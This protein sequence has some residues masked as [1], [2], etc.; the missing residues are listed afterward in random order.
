MSDIVVE[1]EQGPGRLVVAD[2]ESPRAVLL[3]GHGAGG[4]V[5]AFDLGALAQ[6][7]PGRGITV[8]R[9]SQP[10]R[11]AG[12][13]VAVRP[14]KLDEAWA[15]AVA[16]VAERWPGVPLF[17]GGRSAGARVACRWAVE[18]D[19]AGVVAL[20]FPLHP[21]GEPEASRIAELAGAVAPTL[22]VQG[23]SDPFGGPDDVRAA[24]AGVGQAGERDVVE[25]AGATHEMKPRRKSDD[26]AARASAIVE[27]VVSFVN[28][29]LAVTPR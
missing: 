22:V 10:W 12:R 7:L 21:P 27:P 5:D 26:V 1:T 3:L 19:V 23:A 13:K 2:A 11:E 28:E 14:A 25:V 29:V 16:A 6:A 20:S 9:Y 15:P 18:H 4:G 8:A 24:I 17:V